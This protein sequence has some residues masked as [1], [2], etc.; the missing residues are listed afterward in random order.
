MAVTTTLLAIN[1]ILQ[2]HLLQLLAL[3]AMEPPS[4]LDGDAIRNEKVKVLDCLRLPGKFRDLPE[5]IV[6]GQY[7][8]YLGEKGVAEDSQ[9]ETYIATRAYIDNWR[10]GGVP[11]LLRTGKGMS[12]RFTSITLQFRMPPVS[13]F[14]DYEPDVYMRPNHL[15]MRIQ[16]NEGIDLLFDVKKPGAGNDMQPASLN[17][18]YDDFFG[19]QSPEAYQR[20]LQDV[21]IGDQ[22]LFIRSDEVEACWRWTDSLK[23]V[24]GQVPLETYKAGGWDLNGTMNCSANARAA[25]LMASLGASSISAKKRGEKI[26]YKSQVRKDSQA[27]INDYRF[28]IYRNGSRR[29]HLG[30]FGSSSRGAWS[31]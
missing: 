21:I 10:W 17:F 30:G 26:R 20:L 4:T 14:G 29:S 22:A 1:D 3:V 7:D 18:N 6:R 15:R 25:G 13:L 2:N 31:R 23:A 24:L 28:S 8:G 16:P 11:F 9:T 12:S 19:I 27:W 5:H